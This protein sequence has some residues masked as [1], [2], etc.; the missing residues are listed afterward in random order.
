MRVHRVA[1]RYVKLGRTGLDISTVS[2]G[3]WAFGVPD[4]GREAWKLAEAD[5]VPLIEQALQAG[6][7]FFDIANIYSFGVSE[8]ITGRALA[9]RDEIVI[10]TKLSGAMQDGSKGQGLSRKAIM[11]ELDASLSRLGTDYVDLYQIHRR[12]PDTPIVGVTKPD[13]ITEAVAVADVTMTGDDL[14]ELGAG[15]TPRPIS[16]HS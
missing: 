1:M 15:Y 9:K 12:D 6:I 5:A 11:Q 2:R 4:S 8:E 10:A 16:G 13:H 7:N 14:A 3:C